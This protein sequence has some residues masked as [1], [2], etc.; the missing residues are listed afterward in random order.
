MATENQKKSESDVERES[1]HA[2]DVS[3]LKKVYEGDILAVDEIDFT[4]DH[5]DFCVI[6]GPSG[7]G[8]TTTLHSIVGKVT[9]TEG[10][11]HINGDEVTNV[12]THKR[13]IGLVF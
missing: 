10:R 13:D 6:I 5:G 1:Q 4:I 8:K 2:V 7:C 11:V 9:P 3:G 12:P